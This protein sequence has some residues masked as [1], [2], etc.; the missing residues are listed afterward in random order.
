M[1]PF[2]R[3]PPF[4]APSLGDLMSAADAQWALEAFA[5]LSADFRTGRC[6]AEVLR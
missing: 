2:P 1:R 3:L 6:G 4:L 5:C